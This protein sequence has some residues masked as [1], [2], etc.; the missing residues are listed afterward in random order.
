MNNIL[1]VL[2]EI[3]IEYNIRNMHR[4]KYAYIKICIG[5]NIL[6]WIT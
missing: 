4:E 1:T 2:R 5:C 3:C 6:G